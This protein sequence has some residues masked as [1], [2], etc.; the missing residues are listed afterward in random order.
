MV[1]MMMM[2]IND[3]KTNTGIV[4]LYSTCSLTHFVCLLHLCVFP[5]VK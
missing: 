4:I 3:K 1:T 2:T 5:S